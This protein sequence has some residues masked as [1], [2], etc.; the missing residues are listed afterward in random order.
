MGVQQFIATGAI[1]VALLSGCGLYDGIFNE[2]VMGDDNQ[3]QIEELDCGICSGLCISGDCFAV[4]QLAS[5]ARHTCAV[6]ESGQVACWGDN[7]RGQIGAEE[8]S[9]S[10]QPVLADCGICR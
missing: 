9:S 4:E 3:E 1:L 10:S 8:V 7:N 6:V 5:G 2:P